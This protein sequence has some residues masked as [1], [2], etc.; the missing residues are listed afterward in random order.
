MWNGLAR[1]LAMGCLTGC[2]VTTDLPEP[3]PEACESSPGAQASC[4]SGTC[5]ITCEPGL[6]DCDGDGTN[7]CE[8][9]LTSDAAHCGSCER[10]CGGAT[11]ESSAC[12]PT[13]VFG[14]QIAP[15]R[16]VL[17]TEHVYWVNRGLPETSNNNSFPFGSVHRASRTH[18]GTVETVASNQGL[19][20]DLA[21]DATHLYWTAT[22][23]GTLMRW[24]VDGSS[25][26]EALITD[27]QL[28]TGVALDDAAIYYVETG[29]G[30]VERLDKVTGVTSSLAVGQ[31][32]PVFLAVD[33]AHV[34]WANNQDGRVR[35]SLL[36]VLSPGETL[37]SGMSAPLKLAVTDEFLFV[38]N[39]SIEGESVPGSLMRISLG[40]GELVP[41][42]SGSNLLGGLAVVGDMLYFSEGSP[43]YSLKRRPVDLSREAE[44][45]IAGL[46][47]ISDIAGDANGVYFMTSD[48]V[49]FYPP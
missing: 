25:A 45:I 26:P 16:I 32:F 24:P 3:C 12:T 43:R 14:E 10:D 1:I 39:A 20:F 49:Y 19:A 18:E 17:D 5:Q 46:D 40:S 31:A 8:A 44:T 48:S 37:A 21:V 41:V 28:P 4:V 13:L 30:G 23:D 36:D 42:T 7:G 29:A 34:Y 33:E 35:S 22:E 27:A 47:V 6:G 15:G 2:T 9:D 38:L 11:C